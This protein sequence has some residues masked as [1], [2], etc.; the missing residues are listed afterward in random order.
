MRTRAAASA[1]V[2]RE[3]TLARNGRLPIKPAIVPAGGWTRMDV[4]R[5]L[6]GMQWVLRAEYHG[7]MG[8]NSVTRKTSVEI[9]DR[10]IAEARRVLRTS[11]IKDTIHGAL[12][13]VV[14]K[15]ARREEIRALTTMDCLDLADE[16]VMAKAWRR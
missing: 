9:D 8:A 15:E 5:G 11:S 6:A 12:R 7:W 16:R 2:H 3:N 14:Q 10:L 4:R 1:L 13:E